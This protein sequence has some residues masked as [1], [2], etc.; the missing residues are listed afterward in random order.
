LYAHTT[1]LQIL[2]DDGTTVPVAG[3][4]GSDVSV[5]ATTWSNQFC[6]GRNGAG[7]IEPAYIT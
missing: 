2:V 6:R 1:D 5:W 7:S 3:E 4:A